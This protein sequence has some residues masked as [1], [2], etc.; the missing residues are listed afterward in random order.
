MR[1]YV[2]STDG[3]STDDNAQVAFMENPEYRCIEINHGWPDNGELG[4]DDYQSHNWRTTGKALSPDAWYTVAVAFHG[5]YGDDPIFS[6][7]AAE[8]TDVT[9]A[10]LVV[11]QED[12]NLEA[13]SFDYLHVNGTWQSTF[14]M[15]NVQIYDTYG[16]G[17]V[18][19][20]GSLML[21]VSALFGF[22]LTARRNRR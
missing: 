8:G 10:D 13:F 14:Y 1:I 22:C 17:I 16:E 21:L 7:W 20:P 15:D 9:P 19:E 5:V 12:W 4:Y 2:E 11:D 6:I 3:Y 18:P